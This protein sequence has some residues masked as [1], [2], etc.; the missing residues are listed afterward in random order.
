L[1]G[2]IRTQFYPTGTTVPTFS[3]G[4]DDG[5][6]VRDM[7]GKQPPPRQHAPNAP[8]RAVVDK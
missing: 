4:M 8:L 1:P 5:Y 7:I 3:L 6:A 2:N